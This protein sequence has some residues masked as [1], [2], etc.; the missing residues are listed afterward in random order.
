MPHVEEYLVQARLAERRAEAA[1]VHAARLLRAQR[2]AQRA[3]D[4]AQRRTGPGAVTDACAAPP[5]GAA[6]TP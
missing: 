5:C 2:L 3:A 4:R 1:R 6:V